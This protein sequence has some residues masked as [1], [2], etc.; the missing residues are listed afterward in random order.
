M[1]YRQIGSSGLR[2]SEVGLGSWLTYGN[3]TERETA[4]ACIDRAYELGINFFDTANAYNRGQAELVVGEALRKYPRTSYVLAT[5]VY[6]PMGDGP[7]DRGLSRKHIVEQCEASLRRLGVDYIDLY[8]CHRFDSTVSLEE[9]LYALDDLVR[10][11]KILYAGVSEWSA[12]QITQA[13]AISDKRNLRPIIS[14]QPIYNMLVRYIEKE[15]M[16]T[17][18]QL[19]VGQVVFSPLAQGILTGKYRPG[20][21]V[22]RDSRAANDDTNFWIRSYLRDDVLTCVVKLEDIAKS[23]GASLSQL[24]IAWTLR[25]PNVASAI[26]GASRIAQVDENVRAVDLEL[27]PDILRAVDDVLHEIDGFVPI[28]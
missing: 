18:E 20:A 11:G 28:W 6:F 2:V 7:N 22:P 10:A 14:N 8:Q 9:T 27:T 4:V 15:V 26:I 17:S 19:G 21:Q 16:P 5:K 24:A 25:Q 13:V 23:I 12:A 1:Q 3:A